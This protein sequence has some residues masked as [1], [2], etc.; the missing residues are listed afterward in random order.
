MEF[1]RWKS[2]RGSSDLVGSARGCDGTFST[3]TQ[4]VDISVKDPILQWFLSCAHVPPDFCKA[5]GVREAV[6]GPRQ[7]ELGLEPR[8]EFSGAI[9]HGYAFVLSRHFEI[10][11]KLRAEALFLKKQFWSSRKLGT[12]IFDVEAEGRCHSA[13]FQAQA[14]IKD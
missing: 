6:E 8:L 3:E 7:L 10:L 2:G 4:L 14:W 1:V 9:G 11:L 12:S 13:I 5:D